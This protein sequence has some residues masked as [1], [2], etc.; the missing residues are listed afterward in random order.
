MAKVWT[1]EELGRMRPDAIQKLYRNATAL[2]SPDA[3]ALANL[4]VDSG[5]LV[6]ENGGLPHDHPIMLE[7]ADICQDSAAVAEAILASES[8]L[9]ALAGMEHRI[10]TALGGKYGGNYTTN[11]A[12]RCIGAEM[13]AKGWKK[14][15]QKPMPA[16]SIAKSATVYIKKER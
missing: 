10:V 1:L 3:M 13:E 8:G 9:P 14:T 6:E 11:H 7:I 16:G 12:G 4:I 5:L 2:G 15:A